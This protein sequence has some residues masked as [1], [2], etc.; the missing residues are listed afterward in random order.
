MY[1]NTEHSQF[2]SKWAEFQQRW[3]QMEEMSC[4]PSFKKVPGDYVFDEDKS[5]KWNKEQVQKNNE[6]YEKEVARLNTAKN[7]VRD[8]IN[9]DI[10]AFIQEQVGHHLSAKKAKEIWNY[11][12]DHCKTYHVDRRFF[13]EDTINMLKIVLTP[14]RERKT[15]MPTIKEQEKGFDEIVSELDGD[16]ERE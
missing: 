12:N 15:K 2:L 10:C 4:K 9:A 14:E 1:N 7:K 5:V 16:F 8:E 3:N 11:V 6:Q 13:L